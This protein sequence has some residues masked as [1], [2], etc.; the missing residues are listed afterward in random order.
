MKKIRCADA[1]HEAKLG[2]F[3][4]FL[5]F[6]PLVLSYVCWVREKVGDKLIFSTATAYKNPKEGS[7]Y[8][9]EVLIAALLG[10]GVGNLQSQQRVLPLFLTP[11]INL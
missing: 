9:Q 8:V 5:L 3:C 11:C 10:L 6:S 7:K 1:P 4:Y 2:Y